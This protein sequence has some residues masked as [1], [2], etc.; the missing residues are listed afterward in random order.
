MR[1]RPALTRHAAALQSVNAM[2]PADRGILFIATVSVALVLTKEALAVI[3]RQEKP[4]G[5][6]AAFETGKYL[7]EVASQ[8]LSSVFAAA[9]GTYIT[10][11]VGG[12]AA[13]R[14]VYTLLLCTVII[15]LLYLG[16]RA[17][18]RR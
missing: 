11:V 1:R 12:D 8:L 5:L 18:E 6:E 10:E 15:G 16:K 4:K 3:E 2:N 14:P 9:S 13:T 7:V 17:F